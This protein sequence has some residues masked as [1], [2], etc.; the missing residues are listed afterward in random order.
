MMTR[1]D[2]K[3]KQQSSTVSTALLMI[4]GIFALGFVVGAIWGYAF[5]DSA[6]TTPIPKAF[7]EGEI[8]SS[9]LTKT[10]HITLYDGISVSDKV[11]FIKP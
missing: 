5:N 3:E 10:V 1:W 7:A 8:L 6:E 11:T 4:I 9:S 2:E